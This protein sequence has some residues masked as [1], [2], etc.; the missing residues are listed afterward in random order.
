MTEE[1][2]LVLQMVRR[3]TENW[4]HAMDIY[5]RTNGK[6][7]PYHHTVAYVTRGQAENLK[8]ALD[9]ATAAEAKA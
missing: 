1:T 3:Y 2:R 4:G 5:E 6:P 9:A 8:A 7:A